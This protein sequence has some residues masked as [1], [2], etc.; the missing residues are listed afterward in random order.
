M[1]L[2]KNEHAEQYEIKTNPEINCNT[3]TL[4]LLPEFSKLYKE[5]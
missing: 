2:H 3:C 4:N 1:E 5:G